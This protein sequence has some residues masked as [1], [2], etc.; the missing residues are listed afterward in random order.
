MAYG[1]SASDRLAAVRTA[2]DAALNAQS[3]SIA[4]RAKS[5]ANIRELREMEKELIEEVANS[6]GMCS[7]G[8]QVEASR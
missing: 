5:M 8:I 6:G 4:G 7:L 3:Y 2:I 1:S